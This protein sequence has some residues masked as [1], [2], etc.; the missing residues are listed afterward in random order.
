MIN[1]YSAEQGNHREAKSQLK[2]LVKQ[3]WGNLS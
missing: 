1:F 2:E 3:F